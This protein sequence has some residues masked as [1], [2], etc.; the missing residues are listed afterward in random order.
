MQIESTSLKLGHIQANLLIMMS[1]AKQSLVT[2]LSL[3]ND[4]PAEAIQD[5]MRA[6]KNAYAKAD[7]GI[8]SLKQNQGR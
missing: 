3:D 6:I 7:A 1:L 8:A 5:V 4:A 2:A